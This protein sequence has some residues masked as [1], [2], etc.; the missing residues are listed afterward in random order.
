MRVLFLDYTNSIGLGGGQRSLS[1]L[2][3]RLGGTR[4]RPMLACPPGE[5]M[6][7]LVGDQV[8]VFPLPLGAG[9]RT[10]SRFD[11]SWRRIPR[12][13]V[14]SLAAVG[15]LRSIVA[16]EAVS[17]VH[18][19]NLK[20]LLL[21]A[22]AAPE[23]PRVWH[24][25][26]IFPESAMMRRLITLGCKVATKILT[27]SGAVARQLPDRSKVEVLYN[28]VELPRG[29]EPSGERL[30]K[31]GPKTIGYVGRLDPRK[32]LDTLVDAVR[33]VRRSD[34]EVRLLVAGDGPGGAG[35]D[36]PFVTRLPF[37]REMEP[38]WKR[39]DVA[40]TPS[41]EPDAFPRS[42]IE[43]MS[44]AKPVIGAATGGIPEAIEH[45]TN[46]YL[47]RPGDAAELAGKLLDMLAAPERARRMGRAG[48]LACERRFSAEAQVDQLLGIY[49][50]VLRGQNEIRDSRRRYEL[51][52]AGR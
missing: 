45:G 1:L 16:S 30:E 46:G 43:A 49:D 11:A 19:N 24:V 47:F 22:A 29:A 4:Y 7:G 14:S 52:H 2:L 51:P 5:Q 36:E 21:A 25:R 41:V 15:R 28:A 9:F 27:V 31:A 50:E 26:D 33:I 12:A 23:Q 13:A 42:V 3:E 32:G 10:L 48:R 38:V 8:P 18:A 37:Q 39:I 35:L 6:L 20:M 44:Y 34:P 40:V 17:L